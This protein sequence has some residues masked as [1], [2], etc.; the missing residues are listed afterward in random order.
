MRVSLLH[1]IVV[2]FLIGVSLPA[3]A[4]PEL[5]QLQRKETLLFLS[6]LNYFTSKANYES[7]GGSYVDLPNSGEYSNLLIDLGAQ[8][9]FTPRLYLGGELGIANSESSLNGINRTNSTLGEAKAWIQY[10]APVKFLRVVPEATFIYPFNRIEDGTDDVMT[11]EGAMAVQPG[12]WLIKNLRRLDFFGYLGGRY[13][14]EQ[15]SGLAIYRLGS[16]FK[17]SSFFVGASLNGFESVM[18]DKGSEAERLAIVRRVNGGSFKYYAYNPSALEV[19]LWAGMNFSRTSNLRLGLSQTLNGKSYAHGM[20]VHVAYQFQL[21][22]P[23]AIRRE[24]PSYDPKFELENE[25][26]DESLFE[27]DPAKPAR[28][29][30]RPRPLKP[31]GPS[32]EELLNDTMD[33]LEKPIQ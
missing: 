28:R 14:D 1:R 2:F 11:G 20:T 5:F 15:R 32:Q 27:A 16:Q 3:A 17:F 24:Q 18:D 10:V 19:D 23:G 30:P 12:I 22:G 21:L 33:D 31:S 26:Y 7:G 29:R 6:E 13:Q 8:Y 25:K 4:K 9:A